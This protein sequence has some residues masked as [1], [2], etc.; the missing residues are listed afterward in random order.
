MTLQFSG[1]K[2][3]LPSPSSTSTSSSPSPCCFRSGRRNLSRAFVP[4]L[5]LLAVLVNALA[6]ARLRR[7]AALQAAWGGGGLLD[8]GGGGGVAEGGASN[9]TSPQP[10]QPN[11][12]GLPEDFW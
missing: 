6:F 2:T 3:S 11:S 1:G 4:A 8:R 10:P 12:N 9:G 5:V 7:L